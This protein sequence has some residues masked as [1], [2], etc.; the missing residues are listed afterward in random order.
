M[1]RPSKRRSSRAALFKED[2]CGAPG[3]PGPE[4]PLLTLMSHTIAILAHAYGRAL[5]CYWRAV[6]PAPSPRVVAIATSYTPSSILERRGR[7]AHFL[8]CWIAQHC[9]LE[10]HRRENTRKEGRYLIL[11]P[12]SLPDAQ[13]RAPNLSRPFRGWLSSPSPERRE[14]SR[15]KN[16][17]G[18]RAYRGTRVYQGTPGMP[19]VSGYT[20]GHLVYPRSPGIPLDP[21]YT[22][23]P[24]A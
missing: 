18:P 9:G 22:R 20:R 8:P 7:R 17:R 19:G 24:R 11:G 6:N 4:C 3:I 16:T 23:R 1:R 13:L 15:A 5:E 2:Q 10:Q 12:N 14:V 21:G